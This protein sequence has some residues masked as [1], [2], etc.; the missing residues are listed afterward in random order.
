MRE[1]KALNLIHK[2]QLANLDQRKKLK[3]YLR[4]D[5]TET[6]KS[7]IKSIDREISLIEG[8]LQIT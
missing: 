1:E 4:T 7:L 6:A 2:L 5:Q 3:D 8:S